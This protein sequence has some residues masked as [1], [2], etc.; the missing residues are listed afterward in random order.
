VNQGSEVPEYAPGEQIEVQLTVEH[1]FKL[2]SVAASFDHW[3]AT[4]D[5]PS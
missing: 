4:P 3:D 5:S 2:V 1:D